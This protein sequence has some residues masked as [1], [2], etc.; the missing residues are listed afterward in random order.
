MEVTESSRVLLPVGEKSLPT[1]EFLKEYARVKP[2]YSGALKTACSRFEILDD[3]FSMTHGH[4][5]IHHIESRLKT[6]ESCYEKLKRRGF[7]QEPDNL[8]QLTDIAGVRVVCGYIE[9]IYKI[10][11]VFLNQHDVRLLRQKD[12][13]KKPK[14]NGYRS[15][16][17]IVE[18]P[19]SLSFVATAVPV[20]IQLRTI[21]MNMW[22]S[23]E[24]EVS[25]K[26]GAELKKSA[27]T[28]L[29]AC[30]DDLFGVEERMQKIC[31][32]IRALNAPETNKADES[33]ET[34]ETS[35]AKEVN[36]TGENT[37]EIGGFAPETDEKTRAN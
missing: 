34:D 28:E 27:F 2:L 19:V 26:A 5:P 8:K 37:C 12:Y 9:D 33:G 29:K 32:D 21:S 23:L 35:M 18:V 20:E 24:H 4:D 30:A 3:E 10:A 1:A 22:A 17:L 16:H 6:V 14:P 15:L 7:K 13:I 36:E 25:Y 11:R 31:G